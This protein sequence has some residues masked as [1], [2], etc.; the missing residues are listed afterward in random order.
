M[1]KF[2]LSGQEQFKLDQPAMVAAAKDGE[3]RIMDFIGEDMFGTGVS[4]VSVLDYLQDHKGEPVTARINSQGGDVF[5]GLAMYNAFLEHGNVTAV[6]DGL[7]FSAAAIL[8]MG[9]KSVQ[10]KKASNFGIH[11]A[12]TVAGG[13]SVALRG[14][15]EW[16]DVID[17]HQ[18]EIF[19]E[20]TGLG[21]DDVKHYLN[22]SANDGTVWAAADAV[23]VGFADKVIDDSAADGNAANARKRIAEGSAQIRKQRAQAIIRSY[24]K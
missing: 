10:M 12:W 19:G 23:K 8:C 2:N 7:A 11:R 24:R 5:E 6:I 1:R 15:I 16:L 18:M 17:S 14:V 22:G 20:K 21:T 13:N 9:A 4:A 3:L